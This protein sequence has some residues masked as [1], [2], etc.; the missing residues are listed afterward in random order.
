MPFDSN[1]NFT[2]LHNWEDDRLNDIDIVSERHDE[3]DD[4]FAEALSECLLKDGRTS[5]NGNLKMGG[6]QIKNIA[7]GTSSTDA[8]NKNQIDELQANL[9][10]SI[11]SAFSIGDIKASLQTAN[12]HNWLL[13]NGQEVSRIEYSELFELIGTNFGSGDNSKTF[14]LPDYQ[15]KFL[16]GLGGDSATDLYTTQQEGLPNISG[17]VGVDENGSSALSGAFYNTGS[18]VSGAEG[19]GNAIKVGFDASRSNSIY[20]TSSHVTPINQAVNWFIKA[21]GE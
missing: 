4:G 10:K 2:R 16:R 19:G 13:C 14:N 9:I 20:G 5:M 6:F 8:I 12:H 11:T 17:S 3:E 1:G 15:G 7:K 18:S 21:K